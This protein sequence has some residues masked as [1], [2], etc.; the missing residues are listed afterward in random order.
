GR[1]VFPGERQDCEEL[2]GNLVDNACIWAR[3]RVLLTL[4]ATED[5]VEILV[6]D[7]GP[8]IAPEDRALAL[9]RGGRLDEKVAG[10]GLGLAIVGDLVELHRGTWS[11]DRSP[12][13][14]LAAQIRLPLPSGP[15]AAQ[16]ERK[17]VATA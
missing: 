15:S 8:G 2:L 12:M 13:G 11:L 10:T 7:D 9:A 3:S 6:E 14:G 17:A 16:S 4:R 5:I 1:P